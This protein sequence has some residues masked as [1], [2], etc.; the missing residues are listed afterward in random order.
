MEPCEQTKVDARKKAII[1][2]IKPNTT[3]ITII[4]KDGIDIGDL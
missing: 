4:P 1:N 3:T 2:V